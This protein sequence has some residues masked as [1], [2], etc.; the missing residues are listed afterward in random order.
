[1][2]FIVLRLNSRNAYASSL[3]F[4]TEQCSSLARPFRWTAL[5][6]LRSVSDIVVEI[7]KKNI[8][9]NVWCLSTLSENNHKW[10]CNIVAP[11]NH[12]QSLTLKIHMN[13]QNSLNHSNVCHTLMLVELLLAFRFS[14]QSLQFV[15]CGRK[16]KPFRR[17]KIIGSASN[18]SYQLKYC[19]SMNPI[20]D[21]PFNRNSVH[22]KR[23]CVQHL[24]VT[25]KNGIL[26][27]TLL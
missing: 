20:E 17:P 8:S 4:R 24:K 19:Y 21:V 18:R 13:R 10:E 1:M 6:L 15:H 22:S 9:R 12:L 7:W 23:L 2:E 16:F 11:V 5:L 14:W 27:T 3:L 26:Y 25:K